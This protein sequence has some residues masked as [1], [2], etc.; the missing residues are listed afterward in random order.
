MRFTLIFRPGVHSPVQRE[1][2]ALT[3][4]G[5]YLLTLSLIYLSRF[6]VIYFFVLYD[7]EGLSHCFASQEALCWAARG[8]HVEIVRTLLSHPGIS[9]N[10]MDSVSCKHVLFWWCY[11]VCGRCIAN[12]SSAT[13]TDRFDYGW[14]V[15]QQDH[16]SALG[17]AAHGNH[18]EVVE[19]LLAVP[20][21]DVNQVDNV[22][23]LYTSGVW[24]FYNP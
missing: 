16:S 20:G 1:M 21:I 15:L 10:F 22:S 9:V 12:A 17:C 6:V 4:C 2:E 3:L 5:R 7:W 8:G 11:F 24:I 14:F 23:T 13:S 19:A 18:V